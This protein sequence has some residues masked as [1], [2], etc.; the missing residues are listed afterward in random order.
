MMDYFKCIKTGCDMGC[1]GMSWHGDLYA[2]AKGTVIFKSCCRNPRGYE[3]DHVTAGHITQLGDDDE[4][5]IFLV[6][7]VLDV[8]DAFRT[9]LLKYQGPELCGFF[10][11]ERENGGK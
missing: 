6:N 9:T 5:C 1:D 8:S 7:G 4:N 3:Y 2:D 10:G 11:V